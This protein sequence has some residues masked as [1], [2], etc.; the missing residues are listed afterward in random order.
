MFEQGREDY[1]QFEDYYQL[2]HV[3]LLRMDPVDLLRGR[4][5]AKARTV[6]GQLLDTT[7]HT[8]VGSNSELDQM[9]NCLTLK[10]SFSAVSKPNFA[11]K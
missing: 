3:S 2:L 8:Y 1:Y 10:G 5:G 4:C 7:V 9:F 11:S 6:D